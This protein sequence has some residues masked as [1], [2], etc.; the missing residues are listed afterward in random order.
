MRLL[1]LFIA[2]PG[3]VHAMVYDNRY[4]PLLQRPYITVGCCDSHAAVDGFITT[5]HSAIGINE[6]VGIPEI[7]GIFDEAQLAY[8][9]TQAGLPNPLPPAFLDAEIPWKMG[10][11]IQSQGASFS[12][13]QFLAY[14]FSVGI[15][16]LAM[17][18]NSTID[19]VLEGGSK[20]T[21]VING[22]GDVIELDDDRRAMIA[23]LGLS[24]D[25]TQQHGFGDLDVYLRWSDCWKYLC[26]VRTLRVGSRLGML[27]PTGVKRNIYQPASVPFGGN[28]HWGIYGSLD[29]EIEIKEDWKVGVL[30]RASKRFSKTQCQRMPLKDEQQLYGVVVGQASVDPGWTGIFSWYFQVEGL[31]EGFGMRAQYTLISHQRDTWQDK[32]ADKTIPVN[33]CPV[34][35]LS[36][37]GSEYITLAA[38]YDFEKVNECRG[39][40]PIL[41]V[42]WDIPVDWLIAHRSV[43]AFKV[44]FGLEFNF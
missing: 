7:F 23:E 5:S 32:R 2:V 30:G 40:A 14:G 20:T 33:L 22:A 1:F 11:K 36:G 15:Y 29:T 31:R 3:I 13:E 6:E 35:T 26:K 25:H 27:A 41:N 4:F 44:A 18:V 16:G 9:L 8:S 43:R 10:G 21:A 28:G 37:W 12:Y 42:A 24:C 19:F 17:R 34:E 39:H 38:F